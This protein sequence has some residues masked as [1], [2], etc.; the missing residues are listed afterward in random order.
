MYLID[1]HN[2][3]GQIPDLRLD[4]PDDEA[5]LVERL[6]RTM[7][8]KRKRC[9]VVFDHGLPGGASRELSTSNVK[10]VFA[11][12]GTTADAII[13]ERIR[14]TRDTR[15]LTIVS[16]DHEVANCARRAGMTVIAPAAFAAEMAAAALPP[17]RPEDRADIRLSR[18]EVDEWLKLFGGSGE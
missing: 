1:G 8:R 6:R 9:V 11:H 17:D 16:A 12:G 4:D 3:I 7:N 15:R 5:Q 13:C 10:V 14:S 2:L 18:D